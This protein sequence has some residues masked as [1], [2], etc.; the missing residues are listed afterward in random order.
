MSQ[1]FVKLSLLIPVE[2]VENFLSDLTNDLPSEY[3]DMP[4]LKAENSSTELRKRS[5]N[6][7]VKH[8][9]PRYTVIDCTK[10]PSHKPKLPYSE[11]EEELYINILVQNG[12]FQ[13]LP[14]DLKNS[15]H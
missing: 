11:L 5:L 13:I 15:K 1:S 10:E 7:L 4:E 3:M 12:I 2:E 9:P 6:Y 8:I 14:E